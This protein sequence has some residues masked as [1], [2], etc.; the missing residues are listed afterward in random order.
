VA[1]SPIR[2]VNASSG[3]L[4]GVL[5]LEG[6]ATVKKGMSNGN[7]QPEVEKKSLRKHLII[8][9]ELQLDGI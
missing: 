7:L 4:F 8:D 6:P 2:D 5:F 3:V 9:L 1:L